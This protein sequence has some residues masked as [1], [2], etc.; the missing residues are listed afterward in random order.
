MFRILIC[1]DEPT[2]LEKLRRIASDCMAQMGI[3]VQI[4]ASTDLSGIGQ[5]ILASC[6]LALLDIDLAQGD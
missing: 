2:A 6:D 5:R 3:P 4:H 1:D